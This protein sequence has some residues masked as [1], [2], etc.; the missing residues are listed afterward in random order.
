M[1]FAQAIAYLFLGIFDAWIAFHNV[2]VM[3]SGPTGH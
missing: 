2:M 1:T 3:L